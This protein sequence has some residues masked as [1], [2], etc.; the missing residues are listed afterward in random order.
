M[1]NQNMLKLSLEQLQNNYRDRAKLQVAEVVPTVKQV[2]VST[3]SPIIPKKSDTALLIAFLVLSGGMMFIGFFVL[4]TGNTQLSDKLQENVVLGETVKSSS[5]D[6]NIVVNTPIQSERDTEE[7]S[8][9]VGAE[10]NEPIEDLPEIE[11]VVPEKEVISVKILP[12][13]KGGVN[14]RESPGGRARYNAKS[15]EE[16]EVVNEVEGWIEIQF[17][18]ETT[19]WVSSDPSLIEKL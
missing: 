16:F 8:D 3:E 11:E 14:L 19:Y 18:S 2:V 17:N 13:D 6:E 10:V 4:V 5:E 15:G 7:L 12:N 1:L 9:Y